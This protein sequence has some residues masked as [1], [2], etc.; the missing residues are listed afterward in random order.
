MWQ[1]WWSSFHWF[2]RS[3]CEKMWNHCQWIAAGVKFNSFL[4]ALN[5]ACANQA[6]CG[7]RWEGGICNREPAVMMQM[8]AGQ[9]HRHHFGL[10]GW[11]W[12]WT[13]QFAWNSNSPRPNL[14]PIPKTKPPN[15]VKKNLNSWHKHLKRCQKKQWLTQAPKL[16]V[17]II[18]CCRTSTMWNAWENTRG[19]AQYACVETCAGE[20]VEAA[21]RGREQRGLVVV[22]RHRGSRLQN[23]LRR[24]NVDSL[25]DPPNPFPSPKPPSRCVVY[26]PHKE[27]RNRDK[28]RGNWSVRCG[29]RGVP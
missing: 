17:G 13:M 28:F 27:T 4:W 11:G 8:M 7:A 19:A 6:S 20:G 24:I 29:G 2:C 3:F 23:E 25:G 26:P 22:A 16:R 9:A 10:S 1:R 21:E 5:T 14:T 15:V 12:D 18:Q